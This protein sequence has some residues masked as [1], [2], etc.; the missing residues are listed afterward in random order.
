MAAIVEENH[1]KVFDAVLDFKK[2]ILRCFSNAVELTHLILRAGV[3]CSSNRSIEKV[4]LD[5]HKIKQLFSTNYFPI[6]LFEKS[7]CPCELFFLDSC[8][9]VHLCSGINCFS[10]TAINCLH[11]T[12]LRPKQ[13]SCLPLQESKSKLLFPSCHLSV[14]PFLWQRLLDPCW[15]C[16]HNHSS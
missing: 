13:L 8:L 15:L 16:G 3:I 4:P 5:S 1:W 7:I 6:V 10:E 9:F 14:A 2:P 12:F 11:V